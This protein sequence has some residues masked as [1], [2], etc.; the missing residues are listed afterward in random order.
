[1]RKLSYKLSLRNSH[2]LSCN[3]YCKII[4]VFYKR[5]DK[6]FYCMKCFKGLLALKKTDNLTCAIIHDNFA[7]EIKQSSI[8]AFGYFILLEKTV[9]YIIK[10]KIH[11][12]LEIPDLFLVLNTTFN[13]RNKSGISAPPCIFLHLNWNETI[14]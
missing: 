11:G 12:C 13:T 5:V 6:A 2:L 14:C 7:C 3:S 9:V 4:I 1:M 8:T 10:R